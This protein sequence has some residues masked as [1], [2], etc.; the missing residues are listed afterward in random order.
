[1]QPGRNPGL[2]YLAQQTTQRLLPVAAGNVRGGVVLHPKNEGGWTAGP[3]LRGGGLL[4]G[5]RWRAAGRVHLRTC[6]FSK[7]LI[8]FLI[9]AVIQLIL[10]KYH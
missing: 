10:A 4:C 7:L 9:N 5:C 8:F 2:L 6:I 3:G 1:M